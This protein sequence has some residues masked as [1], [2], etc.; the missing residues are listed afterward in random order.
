MLFEILDREN[1]YRLA[2]G[3]SDANAD[4]APALPCSPT[5]QSRGCRRYICVAPDTFNEMVKTEAKKV[6]SRFIELKFEGG[7]TAIGGNGSGA[8]YEY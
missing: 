8:A 1:R 6:K 4:S 2:P 5:H 3:F 7:S